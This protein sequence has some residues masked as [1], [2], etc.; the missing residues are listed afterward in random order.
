MD[1]AS[2]MPEEFISEAIEPVKETFDTHLMATGSPGLPQSFV[3]RKKTITVSK[4]LRT[5]TTTGSCVH[6]SGEK[7]VRR[8][9][10]EIKTAEGLMKIYFDKASPGRRKEMGWRLYTITKNTEGKNA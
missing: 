1:N 6:G 9:W 8:H 2:I 4:L 10:F 5:W 7:Y 3:W